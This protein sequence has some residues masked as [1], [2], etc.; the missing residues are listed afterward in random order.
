MMD[1]V[2]ELTTPGGTSLATNPPLANAEAEARILGASTSCSDKSCTL[3]KQVAADIHKSMEGLNISAPPSGQISASEITKEGEAAP[4]PSTSPGNGGNSEAP[5]KNQGKRQR[6]KRAA[7]KAGV[8]GEASG[9]AGTNANPHKNKKPWKDGKSKR[10]AKANLDAMPSTSTP[11]RKAD[12]SNSLSKGRTKRPKPG[13]GNTTPAGTSR[14][15]AG[16]ATNKPTGGGSKSKGD[17]KETK[18]RTSQSQSG[19][20]GNRKG[21]QKGSNAASNL[22]AN[23]PSYG[24]VAKLSCAVVFHALDRPEGYSREESELVQDRLTKAVVDAQQAGNA[25]LLRDPGGFRQMFRIT[26]VNDKAKEWLKVNSPRILDGVWPGAR[27]Q[28]V[29]ASALPKMVKATLFLRQDRN[30]NAKNL[31]SLIK[32]NNDALHTDQWIIHNVGESKTS[33]RGELVV[34]SVPEEDRKILKP[35][36]DVV[37]YGLNEVTLR[38]ADS[39]RKASPQ[40]TSQKRNKN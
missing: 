21:N 32:G 40:R 34:L 10:N 23:K 39:K 1:N 26:P 6:E 2:K 15:T 27:F 30:I 24:E 18:E 13:G 25:I 16:A 11:K 17:R 12:F 33:Q 35:L 19:A 9:P 4:P 22:N 7:E 36:G 29:E 38:F 14:G 5:R 8:A 28:V 3:D 20:S 37:H 31:L